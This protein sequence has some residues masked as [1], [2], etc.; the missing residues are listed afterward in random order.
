MIVDHEIERTYFYSQQSIQLNSHVL[1]ISLPILTFLLLW[2]TS[3]NQ[4]GTKLTLQI[5]QGLESIYN[6]MDFSKFDLIYAQ[7]ASKTTPYG[8]SPNLDSIKAG[9]E[10]TFEFYDNVQTDFYDPIW[11][12]G[13]LAFYFTFKADYKKLTEPKPVEFLGITRMK[14]KDHKIIEQQVIYD[15]SSVLEQIGYEFV[16]PE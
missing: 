1:K 11:S 4:D 12:G 2:F 14:L 5:E 6:E 16:K 10:K 3:C 15:R 9:V 8:T 13:E 7:E